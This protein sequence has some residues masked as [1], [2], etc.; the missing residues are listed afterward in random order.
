MKKILVIFFVFS[1]LSAV[2][3]EYKCTI[4]TDTGYDR[5]SN[6]N[7]NEIIL[8]EV[9]VKVLDP[10]AGE[11][12]VFPNQNKTTYPE[13]AVLVLLYDYVADPRN[14]KAD[15]Y[16]G[17]R[18][19]TASFVKKLKYNKINQPN[20]G[21]RDLVGTLSGVFKSDST[22]FTAQASFGVHFANAFCQLVKN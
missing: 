10:K 7:A 20:V 9:T 1:S 21:G 16:V 11:Y 3:A 22:V 5:E 15:I 13:G 6:K 12:Q 2:G 4:N 18:M 17:S 14:P 8:N 19:F